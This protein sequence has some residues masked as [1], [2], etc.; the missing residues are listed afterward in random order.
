VRFSRSA[1]PERL[2]ELLASRLASALSYPEV[3]ASLSVLPSGYRH[4][5]HQVWLGDGDAAYRRAVQGLVE[6]QAHRAAGVQVYP[7]DASLEVGT[8]V[9]LALPLPGIHALA[10]C[11]IVTVVREAGRFGFAYGTVVGHP[12]QGEEAFV[13]ERVGDTVRFRITAFSRPADPLARAGSPVTR[14]IQRRVTRGYLDGLRAY[15]AD[16]T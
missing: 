4:D 1:T 13:V 12:E 16:S 11:R 5:S 9:A 8:T 7:P 15:V 2:S 14:Y 3:G 6:W 10:A